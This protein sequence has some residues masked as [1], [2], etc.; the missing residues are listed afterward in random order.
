MV[1]HPLRT[2]NAAMMAAL[3]RHRDDIAG[4]GSAQLGKLKE[5]DLAPDF[6]GCV[7]PNP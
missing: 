1:N 7:R 2:T 6:S 4:H 5:R 3:A